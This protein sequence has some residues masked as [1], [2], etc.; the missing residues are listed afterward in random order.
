MLGEIAGIASVGGSI[1]G[2]IGASSR[3]KKIQKAIKRNIKDVKA[4]TGDQVKRS[5]EL[6]ATKQTYLEEGDPFAEMGKFIFGDPSQSTF[7]NLRKSQSDF[8]E[9]AAGKT[10]NFSKE[11]A[12]IVQGALANT[13]GGPRGSFE[14]VS[15]KNL[16]NFRQGGLQSALGVTDFFNRTG[17]QLTNAKFGILDQTFERQMALRQNEMNQINSLRLG[18]AEQSGVGWMAAGNVLNAIGGAA[19]N[20]SN[21]LQNNQSLANQKAYNDRYLDILGGRQNGLGGNSGGYGGGGAAMPYAE[22]PT[23]NNGAYG[24]GSGGFN[25]P[26]EN[27]TSYLSALFGINQVMTPN[28]PSARSRSALDMTAIYLSPPP[29][30]VGGAVPSLLNNKNF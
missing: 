25:L 20:Y 5:D 11:V 12:N 24:D 26:Q 22:L 7:S 10:Q 13:F 23:S 1:L 15:A 18:K 3:A 2:G 14:N 6:G 27:D 19:S 17:S 28:M 8:A 9:L 29:S 30:V 4:F 16:F 21:L